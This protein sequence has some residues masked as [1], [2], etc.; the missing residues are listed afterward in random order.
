M[1]QS[2]LLQSWVAFSSPTQSFPPYLGDGS[3][4]IRLRVWTPPPQVTVQVSH[5]DQG[6]HSPFIGHGDF[7]HGSVCLPSP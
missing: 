3:L 6:P 5:R 4:Q 1:G 7:W 2:C